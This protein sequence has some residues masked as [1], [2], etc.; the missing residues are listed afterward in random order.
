MTKPVIGRAGARA[1]RR[2]EGSAAGCVGAP[3]LLLLDLLDQGGPVELKERGRPVLVPA[4]FLESLQ[5][6]VVLEFPD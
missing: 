6:E 5:D 1:H 4:G 3:E 2:G